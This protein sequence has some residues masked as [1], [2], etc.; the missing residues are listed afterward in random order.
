MF[1]MVLYDL[2]RGGV[3]VPRWKL[4]VA[5]VMLMLATGI[6]LGW[7]K[8]LPTVKTEE[9]QPEMYTA[10][11]Q[12]LKQL[13]VQPQDMPK[14]IIAVKSEGG[15]RFLVHMQMVQGDAWFELHWDGSKWEVKGINPPAQ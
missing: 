3:R 5:A 8:A 6:S 13:R 12:W 10:V 7:M 4:A 2:I 9:D 15:E 1:H 11:E 14:K